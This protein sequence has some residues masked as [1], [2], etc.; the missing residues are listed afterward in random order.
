M[1]PI[2]HLVRDEEVQTVRILG[3]QRLAGFL[4]ESDTIRENVAFHPEVS[5]QNDSNYTIFKN[6]L[7]GVK[8]FYFIYLC[9]CGKCLL[10]LK[11]LTFLIED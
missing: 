2:N 3:K 9:V 4:L 8:L 6:D 10:P 11:I 1:A 7:R 5:C